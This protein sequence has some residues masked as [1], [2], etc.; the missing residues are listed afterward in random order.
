MHVKLLT[1]YTLH[2]YLLVHVI[3]KKMKKV[4]EK[5]LLINENEVAIAS[6]VTANN[7]LLAVTIAVKKTL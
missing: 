1:S 4:A 2:H 3:N 6:Y 5:K 7:R